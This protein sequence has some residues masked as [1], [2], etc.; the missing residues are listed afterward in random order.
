MKFQ[1]DRIDGLAVSAYAPSWLAVNGVRYSHSLLINAS[2]L[3]QA[4]PC[5]YFADIETIH[6]DLVAPQEAEIV[7][8]GCGKKQIFPGA[9]LTSAFLARGMGLETMNTAAACR[10]FNILAAEGRKVAAILLLEEPEV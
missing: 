5:N 1:P 6:L 2:G 3:V 8:L 9:T 10:T 7:L 4:W